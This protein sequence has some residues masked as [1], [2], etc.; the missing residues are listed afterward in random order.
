MQVGYSHVKGKDNER[1]GELF[2]PD[3]GAVVLGRTWTSSRAVAKQDNGTV[4]NLLKN[5]FLKK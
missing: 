5:N 3:S 2:K 1:A 4:E